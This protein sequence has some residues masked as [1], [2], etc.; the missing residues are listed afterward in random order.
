MIC[1]GGF[2]GWRQLRAGAHMYGKEKDFAKV[3]WN[4]FESR[5]AP[6][7]GE[8]SPGG[9]AV[10]DL[11]IRRF[12]AGPGLRGEVAPW[13]ST[14]VLGGLILTLPLLWGCDASVGKA[15]RPTARVARAESLAPPAE[16][17]SMPPG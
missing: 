9:R 3:A 16:V 7:Q 6:K 11:C 4:W 8:R 2:M 15:D 5:T 17:T 14:L 12:D 10:D 1:L 13:V